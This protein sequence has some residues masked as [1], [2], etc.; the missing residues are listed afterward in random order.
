MPVNPLQS[1]VL[2]SEGL[3]S[4]ARWRRW[5]QRGRDNDA[6]LL[7][8]MRRLFWVA[9]AAVVGAAVLLSVVS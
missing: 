2:T 7:R 3:T 1:A 5:E 8:G 9:V 6:H 4:E